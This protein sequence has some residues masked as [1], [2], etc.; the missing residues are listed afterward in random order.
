MSEILLYKK[1]QKAVKI[2]LIAICA[3]GVGL[4]IIYRETPGSFIYLVGWFNV[5]FFGLGIAVSIFQMFDRRPQ[6]RISENGI[7]DRTTKQD[8]I[9]WHQIKHAYPLNIFKQKF[10]S[11]DLVDTF[12][13]K[14]KPYKW[15]SRI[16][17]F[18]GA[19]K[20]NLQV[21]QLKIDEVTLTN[22]I[23][24]I[25]QAEEGNRERIIKKYF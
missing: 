18:V 12:R 24:E 20:V 14:K 13:I 25:I 7:W 5:L 2:L 6:I 19:Q 11:L 16:N 10:V 21:S 3:V 4:F 9:G 23:N 1:P 17:E 8:Q 22:F 15:A